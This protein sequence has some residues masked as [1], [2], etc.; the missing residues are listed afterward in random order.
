MSFQEK[1]L[2]YKSKY[3]DLKNQIGGLCTHVYK[4]GEEVIING[5]VRLTNPFEDQ[6]VSEQKAVIIE[7]LP[8]H[9]V[10][11]FYIVRLIGGQFNGRTAVEITEQQIKKI[12]NL[13]FQFNNYKFITVPI[14]PFPFL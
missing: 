13:I 3:L 11:C 14:F 7:L 9:N 10:G 5:N 12:Q 2:K 1:Y 6:I 8:P 4:V